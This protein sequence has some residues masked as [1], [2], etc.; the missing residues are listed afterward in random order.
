MFMYIKIISNG[1]LVF[2]NSFSCGKVVI[3]NVVCN[4]QPSLVVFSAG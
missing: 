4:G 3:V 1:L 2:Q